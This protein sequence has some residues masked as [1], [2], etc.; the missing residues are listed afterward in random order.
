MISDVHVFCDMDGVL[1][2]W[3]SAFFKET[4]YT[5][6]QL[7]DNKPYRLIQS[8]PISW[9]DELEWLPDGK[10]LWGYLYSHFHHLSILSSP[11]NGDPEEKSRKGKMGWIERELDI[12]P[13]QVI[14]QSNKHE[15]VDQHMPSI[16]IDDTPKKI[17]KWLN[18]G[19]IGIL[20]KN[21]KD[22]IHELET[23]VGGI[24]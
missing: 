10:H 24:S 23:I 5:Y 21:T 6:E 2:D 16:L 13:S 22:T 18:A 17:T 7:Q 19:G 3:E 9:W 14:L 12:L 11:T 15:Y 20:H 4:G 8:F 1:V